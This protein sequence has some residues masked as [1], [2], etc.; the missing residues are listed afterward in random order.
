MTEL[1]RCGKCM[2]VF[3]EPNAVLTL[4]GPESSCPFCDNTNITTVYQCP[5][6]ERIFEDKPTDY[7][8]VCEECAKAKAF[9]KAEPETLKD[10]IVSCFLGKELLEFIFESEKGAEVIKEFI[11]DDTG[12][13][14]DWQE[15]KNILNRR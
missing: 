11:A 12:H 5:E 15:R 14:L 8:G 13:F 1:L 10:Y 2:G 4:Y 9:E 7:D 3:T 6:C